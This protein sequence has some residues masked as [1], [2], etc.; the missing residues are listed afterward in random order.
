M[1]K[2]NKYEEKFSL[3]MSFEEALKQIVKPPVEKKEK[4]QTKVTKSKE[5]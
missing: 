2:K 1:S 4:P 3:D 5:Q